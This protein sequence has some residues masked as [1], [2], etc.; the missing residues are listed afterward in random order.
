M[1][2]G[3]VGSGLTV[4][5]PGRRERPGA[6]RKEA[7]KR[8]AKRMWRLEIKWKSAPNRK[9]FGSFPEALTEKNPFQ[10]IWKMLAEIGILKPF[11]GFSRMAQI[12]LVS[13]E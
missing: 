11:C 8:K 12:T 6:A 1:E 9:H 10:K 4:A 5:T 3:A 13:S 2:A 7:G